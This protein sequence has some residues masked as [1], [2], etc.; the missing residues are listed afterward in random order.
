MTLKP[1]IKRTL[2]IIIWSALIMSIIGNPTS[3]ASEAEWLFA[4]SRYPLFQLQELKF[5][6]DSF[7]YARD[8]NFVKGPPKDRIALNVDTNILRHI[9]WT[10]MVHG[11]SDNSQYRWIGLRMGFGLNVTDHIQFGYRHHSEH[12]LDM[13]YP[14]GSFP[15]KDSLYIEILLFT[16]HKKD[17]VF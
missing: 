16:K 5:E 3:K 14:H 2:N 12:I 11:T 15:V 17:G 9:S 13:Q 7:L 8:P 6:Y 4:D 1:W 10:S